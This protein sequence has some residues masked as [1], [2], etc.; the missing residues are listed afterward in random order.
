MANVLRT[1]KSKE[2]F[3]DCSVDEPSPFNLSRISSENKED[4]EKQRGRQGTYE[5]FFGVVLHPQPQVFHAGDLSL[6]V[7]WLKVVRVTPSLSV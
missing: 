7:A 3:G 4:G 5:A 2:R 6:S 1:P